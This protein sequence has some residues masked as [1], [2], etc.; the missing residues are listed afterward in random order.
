MKRKNI[1]ML[2]AA[3]MMTA[4]AYSATPDDNN[5]GVKQTVTVNEE[6]VNG[7]VSE[8][9]IDG[10]NAVRLVRNAN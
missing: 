3:L 10:N 8:I 5:D 4:P 7:T 2:G 9:R 6:T 1:L